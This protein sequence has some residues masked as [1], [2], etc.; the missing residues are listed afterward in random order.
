MKIC[1][2]NHD[3]QSRTGA[4]RFYRSFSEAIKKIFPGISIEVLTSENLLYPNKIKLLLALPVIRKIIKGCDIVHALDGWPYGIIGAL[5]SLGLRKKLI[6][7]AIGTGA[8]KPLYQPFKRLLMKWAY[9]RADKV[10]AVSHNTKKE[11]LKVIPDLNIEVI[12]HGVDYQKFETQNSLAGQAQLTTYNSLRPYILSVGAW[13]PRKGFEYSIKAFESVKEKFPDLNYV[14][15]SNAPEEIKAKYKKVTF[16][17][18]LPEEDLVG[19]YKNAELFILLPQDA[20]KDI[21]GFGLVFLE[22]AAAGLPVIATKGTSSE[23]AVLDGRNGFLVPMGDFEEATKAI[24]KLLKEDKLKR[25]F[26]AESL[27]FAKEM[28]WD[29]A[30]HSYKNIYDSLQ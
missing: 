11:I 24:I 30:A 8:V 28:S 14:I 13:K 25:N 20:E 23:D 16:L 1:Y 12:N 26:S 9:R 2:L 6:I 10:V 21:E 17:N 29:K 15:V 22:A 4:G 3:T 5:A 19:L 7:T 27:K 18:N